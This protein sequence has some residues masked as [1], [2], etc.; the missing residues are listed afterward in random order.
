MTDKLKKLISDES[1]LT[2]TGQIALSVETPDIRDALAACINSRC[3]A[4]SMANLIKQVAVHVP[5][6]KLLAVIKVFSLSNGSQLRQALE[7]G[8]KMPPSGKAATGS[9]VDLG[10]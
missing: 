10:I 9:A 5:E 3:D 2:K 7:K 4:S 6:D 1:E 8:F